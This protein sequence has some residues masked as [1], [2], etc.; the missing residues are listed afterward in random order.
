MTDD[1][2]AKVIKTAQVL[3]IE[4]DRLCVKRGEKTD[5]VLIALG[6]LARGGAA[7]NQRRRVHR[8]STRGDN[9]CDG[10]RSEKPRTVELEA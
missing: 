6:L 9:G 3:A 5:V 8:L 2:V 4:I 1:E 10:G 7:A